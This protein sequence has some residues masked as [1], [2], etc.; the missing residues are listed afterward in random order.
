[1]SVSMSL[2]RLGNR[3]FPKIEHPFNLQNEGKLSYARWQY[4]RGA[5]TIACYREA[6]T[7]EQMF[8]GKEVLDMGCGAGGKSLYYASLGAKSV[9]GVE[10]V[11]H[12]KA[13]AESLAAELGL[14]DKFRF[15][16]AS[17]LELPFPD[18]SFD[19]IIM[20]DFFEHVSE[21][22]KALKEALRLLRPDGRI[23]VNFPPYWH[24]TGYHMSDAINTPW[25]HLFFHD[26]QLIAAY[27]ELIRGLPD[28][29]DRLDLRFT[30]DENG[31]DQYTYIN[32]M[33]LK[34]AKRILKEL[35]I[36]PEYYKEIPLRTYFTPLAR[37]PAVKEMFVKMAVCVIRK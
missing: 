31:E 23:F 21:P 27:K 22:E 36:T 26:K 19:T 6:Y 8:A 1:M 34:R 5:D 7:G 37:L 2:I 11:E 3:V 28:E 18:G 32:K 33:T 24:P 29:Q 4:E 20:N 13:E 15:V 16:C 12:Y 25:V 14:S 10:I 9:T 17:A 30:K 35:D